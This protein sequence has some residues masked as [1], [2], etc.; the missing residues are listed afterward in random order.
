MQL[1]CA[2]YWA[3]ENEKQ[4]LLLHVKGDRVVGM[5]NKEEELPKKD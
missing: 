1:F 3:S 5:L 4:L 2:C